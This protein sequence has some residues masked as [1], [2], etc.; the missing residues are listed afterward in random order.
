MAPA[1][2]NA[3][4]AVAGNY[5][6]RALDSNA[7]DKSWRAKGTLGWVVGFEPTTAGATVRSSTTELHP[8]CGETLIIANQS[9]PSSPAI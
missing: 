9:R 3:N 2:R 7:V 1:N 4:T 5:I 8:P 6:A